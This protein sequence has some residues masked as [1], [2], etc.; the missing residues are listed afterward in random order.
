MTLKFHEHET[1][2]GLIRYLASREKATLCDVQVCDKHPSPGARVEMTFRLG[3]QCYAIEHT[4]IEPFEGFME[5]QN[6][7]PL[8]FEPLERGIIA[9]LQPVLA[10]DVIFELRLPVLAFKGRKMSD[11]RDIHAALV[12]WVR[13]T[14]RTLPRGGYFTGQ[15]VTAQPRGVP[16]GVSLVRF[17]GT[18]FPKPFLLCHVTNTGEEAR[19][20]RIRRACNDKFPK[21]ATWKHSHNARTILILESNDVQLTSP[22]LVTEALMSAAKARSDSPDETYMVA[23]SM[24]PWWVWPLLKNGL[25]YFDLVARGY[26]HFKMDE[27]G[28]VTQA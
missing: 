5:L 3:D 24:T 16:F 8:W 22:P 10:P 20:Q 12:E 17:D 27:S 28:L 14:A 2:E 23:T 26:A 25:S 7:T 4:G 11:V 21:L 13:A 18:P 1:C 15:P 9:A 6:R 19:V